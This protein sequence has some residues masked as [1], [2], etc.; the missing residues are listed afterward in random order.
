DVDRRSTPTLTLDHL[1]WHRSDFEFQAGMNRVVRSQLIPFHDIGR[2]YAELLCDVPKRISRLNT[3][4]GPTF[5]RRRGSHLRRSLFG[6]NQHGGIRSGVKPQFLSWPDRRG[7]AEVVPFP[8][9]RH[10]HAESP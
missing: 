9:F 2:A 6:W 1:Q 8:N 3:I 10:G 4:N 7:M 5:F